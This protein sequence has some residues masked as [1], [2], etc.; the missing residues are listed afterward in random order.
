MTS[1]DLPPGLE[2]HRAAIVRAAADVGLLPEALATLA[3]IECPAGEGCVSAAGARGLAQL[4]PDTAAYVERQTGWP[5]STRHDPLTSLRCG[6]WYYAELVAESGSYA[7]AGI[8]YH[9]GQWSRGYRAARDPCS[10][11][12]VSAGGRRWCEKAGSLP[13]VPTFAKS[14]GYRQAQTGGFVVQ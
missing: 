11:D 5:C 9:D 14:S 6:G 10:A 1:F 7:V 2:Q 12:G 8:G 4:M 3:A 13:A